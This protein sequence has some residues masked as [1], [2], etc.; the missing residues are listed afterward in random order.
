MGFQSPNKVYVGMNEGG[1]HEQ[2]G[3][4]FVSCGMNGGQFDQ[5]MQVGDGTAPDEVQSSRTGFRAVMVGWLDK[6][7]PAHHTFHD[8][9]A[10]ESEQMNPRA[11]W[12]LQ[13]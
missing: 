13:C 3:S 9:R 5:W 8:K 1:F 11:P 2:V 10:L 7:E 12:R 6:K 4:N